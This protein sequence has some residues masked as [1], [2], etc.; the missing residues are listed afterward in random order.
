[1][2]QFA[3]TVYPVP[4]RFIG[5][6][7]ETSPGTPVASTATMALKTMKPVDKFTMLE[8]DA[9]RGAQAGLYNLIQ[10]V[11]IADISMGGPFFADTIGYPL[12]GILGD[13]WQSVNGTAGTA[14]TLNG[15]VSVGATSV[16]LTSATGFSGTTIFAVGGT[17]TT[18][19]EVRQGISLVG[20]VL[21]FTPP[22]YQAHL[23]AAAVTPYSAAGIT[24]NHNFALLNS[25]AGAGGFAVAQPAVYTITD[26]TGVPASTGARQFAYAVPTE[27]TLTGTATGLVEW[28]GKFIAVG[29]TIASVTPV[30]TLSGVAPQPSWNSTVTIGGSPLYN[31]VEYK[32]TLM[33]KA[34]PEFTNS[35]QQAPYSIP[36]GWFTAGVA[37]EFNPATSEGELLYYLNNSQ[38]TLAVTSSN[39]LSGTSAASITYTAQVA[40]FDTGEYNDSKDAFGFS[41]TAK[42]VANT[43]NVGPSSGFGPI[44]I[45]LKNGVV[46]Y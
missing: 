14:T 15:G 23:T 21:Y 26:Y 4:T 32:F 10:G 5:W 43:T 38:P 18:A 35:A 9:W 24:Y 25:G 29:S 41:D 19:E 17:G 3:A 11:E 27:V 39:G 44:V 12:N 2:P 46:A 42:L 1:M 33:R 16:T 22:L 45:T 7:K 20:S 8:D 34:A 28:E 30:N 6:G 37:L 31:D 13:Y 36:R 40:A